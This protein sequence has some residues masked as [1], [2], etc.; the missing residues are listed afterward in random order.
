MSSAPGLDTVGHVMMHSIALEYL[1]KN[2]KN[3]K[4]KSLFTLQ[5]SETSLENLRVFK[6]RVKADRF[7]QRF[8]NTRTATGKKAERIEIKDV[9]KET[10]ARFAKD[11]IEKTE[12]SLNDVKRLISNEDDPSS[13]LEAKASADVHALEEL[14]KSL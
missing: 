13:S 9:D 4:S 3:F 2:R 14:K 12:K 5:L 1:S 8:V 10:S 11:L 7:K 6:N